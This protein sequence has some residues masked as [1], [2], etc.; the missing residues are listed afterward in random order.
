MTKDLPD[1]NAIADRITDGLKRVAAVMRSDEWST[2]QAMSITPTQLQILNVLE[3]RMRGLR[4]T[5]IAAHLGVSQ[6][7]ATDSATA[8]LRKGYVEKVAGVDRRSS[9]LVLTVEGRKALRQAGRAE[10]ATRDAV[11]ELP[12]AE[13]EELLVSLVRVINTLQEAGAVPV[14]R[15]CVTCKYFEPHRHA[16]KQGPHHCHF[17]NAPLRRRD[18][19]VDCREHEIADPDTR[20]A[21]WGS[22]QTG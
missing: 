17:V 2:A 9:L 11:E 3:G 18:F 1:T 5:E 6:P 20:A 22:L 14:Q 10:N 19:R 16:G 13:Q 12:A 8:L 21:T 7:T 4:V 15:M